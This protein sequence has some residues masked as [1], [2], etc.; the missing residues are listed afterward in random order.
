LKGYRVLQQLFLGFL[1]AFNLSVSH[2][3]VFK[4]KDS[5]GRWH[6]S[7]APIKQTGQAVRRSYKDGSSVVQGNDFYALLNNKYRPS[8]PVQKAT[9]AVVTVKSKLGSGSGFFV[10]DDCFLITNK[11]VIRPAK[12]TQWD[13]TQAQIQKNADTFQRARLQIDEQRQR[14]NI[15][16]EKLDQYKD[17]LNGLP[18]GVVKDTAGRE[19]ELNRAAYYRDLQQL[20]TAEKR[21]NNDEQQFLKQQS[22]FNFSSS[23]AQVAKSFD[24]ILKDNTKTSAQLVKV[25]ANDDL[26]LLKIN[27]CKAPYLL[28]ES[29]SISQG[30]EVYAIGSPLGLRD[31]LTKG[32][33]TQIAADGILTD[34]QILPGNSGGP[35]IA[36][37]GRVIGVNTI[38][39]AQNNALNP[40]FGVAIP[41][42]KVKQNFA[43]YLR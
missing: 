21:F 7:D 42:N 25:S 30:Q 4:Y 23:V 39:V 41:V 12:G 38:K 22:D 24:I 1:L 2:T 34:A 36:N 18:D 26:A 10:S 28:F 37:D 29:S 43:S 14:L 40:G 15:N 8:N 16:K 32:T 5:E 9:L 19:Y 33:V 35:L 27:A 3:E 6:F 20:T 31:Q 11:H 17:Y 13:A